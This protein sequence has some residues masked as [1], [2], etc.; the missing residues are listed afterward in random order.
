MGGTILAVGGGKGGVGR[1]TVAL[2]LGTA[3]EAA[4]YNAVV[5]DLDLGMTDM[6]TQ[7]EIDVDAGVHDV[8]GGNASINDAVI[9]REDGLALVP[10]SPTLSAFAAADEEKLAHVIEPLAAAHDVV[11]VDT[12][13][14]L[15]PLHRETFGL[16][17]GTILV[18]T[19]DDAS[20]ANAEKTGKVV[21]HVGSELVGVVVSQATPIDLGPVD[22]AFDQPL[23]TV[24][25]D[26]EIRSKTIAEDG[27]GRYAF[28]R[29]TEAVGAYHDDGELP[30]EAGQ[31]PAPESQGS[32]TT[33]TEDDSLTSAK[34]E[35]VQTDGESASG[36]S[37]SESAE[38]DRADALD[39]TDPLDALFEEA[40]E[41]DEE[42]RIDELAGRIEG[43]E[44]GA[45]ATRVRDQVSKTASGIQ[46]TRTGDAEASTTEADG[47]GATAADDSGAPA[48][49]AVEAV[50]DTQSETSDDAA[51]EWVTKTPGGSDDSESSATEQSAAD[52][53]E[54]ST[55][56][57]E[58]DDPLE[59][60]FAQQGK[61]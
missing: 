10:G 54:E 56:R 3:L 24:P 8:L 59:E 58:D 34:T 47:D 26:A 25:E 41:E 5:A 43:S 20:I 46:E 32:A 6:E 55:V 29:L 42:S 52:A 61:D 2:N 50:D 35:T 53:G 31:L 37:G 49:E 36:S 4:G 11:I 28:E 38:S 21:D 7:L 45:L 44:V 23:F 12:E 18:T 60:L 33:E 1:T 16:A 57:E 9:E 17:H 22:D 13:A 14:S 39:G 40:E 30:A 19:A 15:S 48:A 27:A 51:T